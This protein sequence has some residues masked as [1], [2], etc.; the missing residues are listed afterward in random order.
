MATFKRTFAISQTELNELVRT[1][2][3]SLQQNGYVGDSPNHHKLVVF[4]DNFAFPLPQRILT[5]RNPPAP[6]LNTWRG[7]VVDKESQR[8]FNQHKFR[9][10]RLY[11]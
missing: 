8:L 3:V 5:Q 11:R 4:S 10:W 7:P 9:N 2:T 6:A 1:G